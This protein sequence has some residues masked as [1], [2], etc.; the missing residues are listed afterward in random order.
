MAETLNNMYKLLID[1]NISDKLKDDIYNQMYKMVNGKFPI[2]DS[3]E[4]SLN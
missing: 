4:I 3:E 2:C 1:N